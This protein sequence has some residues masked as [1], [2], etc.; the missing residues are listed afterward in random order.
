MT[1]ND[2]VD[3]LIAQARAERDA[4]SAALRRCRIEFDEQLAALRKE[5][6]GAQR[7][8]IRLQQ[9]DGAVGEVRDEAT[10]LH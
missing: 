3:G 6:L 2:A 7:E 8:L 4:F 10:T 5:L 9:I 1:Y